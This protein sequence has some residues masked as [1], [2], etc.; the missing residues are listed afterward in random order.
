LVAFWRGLG[1][2]AA[3]FGAALA[4]ASPSLVEAARLDGASAPDDV[5]GRHVAVGARDGRSRRHPFGGRRDP[6]V[7]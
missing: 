1:Y 2:Y 6:S 7:R 4:S 5:Q 3:F